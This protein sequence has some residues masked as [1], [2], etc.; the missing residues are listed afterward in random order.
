MIQKKKQKGC[1]SDALGMCL[2][3]LY[4]HKKSNTKRQI[5]K[6]KAPTWEGGVAAKGITAELCLRR[7]E[8]TPAERIW[9]AFS[10]SAFPAFLWALP[11]PRRP[12]G[13][14]CLGLQGA[15]HQLLLHISMPGLK[16]V[17]AAASVSPKRDCRLPAECLPQINWVSYTRVKAVFQSKALWERTSFLLQTKILWKWQQGHQA[18]ALQKLRLRPMQVCHCTL[19]DNPVRICSAE[20]SWV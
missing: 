14:R 7:A 13:L 3:K 18:A 5:S 15:A 19:W 2:I 20:Q 8:E 17:A 10:C 4:T 16:C 12:T 11:Y 6:E 1:F 9:Q